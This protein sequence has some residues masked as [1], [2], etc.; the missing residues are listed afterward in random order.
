MKTKSQNKKKVFSPSFFVAI[1]GCLVFFGAAQSASAKDLYVANSSQGSNSGANCANARSVD[2]FSS[3]SS[4][5]GAAGNILPGDTVH[6]CGTIDRQ[7]I[8]AGSGS[9]GQPVTILFEPGAKYSAGYI[10]KFDIVGKEY[11]VVDGGMDGVIEATDNGEGLTYTHAQEAMRIRSSSNIEVKNLKIDNVYQ[12][13][14]GSADTAGLYSEGIYIATESSSSNIS[15]HDCVIEDVATGINL[16]IDMANIHFTGVELANNMIMR[17]NRGIS[18]W[19]TN[20]LS[21]TIDQLKIHHNTIQ[22]GYVWQGDGSQGFGIRIYDQSSGSETANSFEDLRINNNTIGSTGEEHLGTETAYWMRIEADN[23]NNALIFNNVF[24]ASDL[25]YPSGSGS[26]FF[27]RYA[28]NVKFFNNTLVGRLSVDRGATLWDAA[29]FEMKNNI[30]SDIT[31]PIQIFGS[32]SFS[33]GGSDYNVYQLSYPSQSSYCYNDY[34]CYFLSE[35]QENFGLDQHSF[36]INEYTGELD[37]NSQARPNVSSPV[38]NMGLDLSQYFDY[39]RD[40][41]HR[42]QGAGWDMGA[43]EYIFS[44]FDLD[45]PA[46]PSGLTV[47]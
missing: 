1:F 34:T 28:D 39:D 25:S 23:L 35:W 30:F 31:T 8:V 40:D 45:P 9:A 33:S 10:A 3:S 18:V 44:D 5:G 22:D 46:V 47:N 19:L 38:I 14:P 7:I 26:L 21:N 20:G 32:S 13:I 43:F 11:I 16:Q 12:K 29:G 17:T 2:W 24:L 42:P 15:I 41:A 6:L 27:L 4:W 36:E 37:L